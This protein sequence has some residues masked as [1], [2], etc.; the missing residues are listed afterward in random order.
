MGSRGLGCPGGQQP[1]GWRWDP[2]ASSVACGRNSTRRDM[3]LTLPLTYYVT[4]S[5]SCPLPPFPK[6]QG[7]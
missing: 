2:E 5:Q 7:C 3:A 6:L 1:A 4:W